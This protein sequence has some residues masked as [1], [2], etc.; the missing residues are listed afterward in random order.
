LNSGAIPE[1]ASWAMLLGG[2]GVVG[3]ALRRRSSR[4]TV[5]A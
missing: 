1:P 4:K 5:A 2:L 3:T